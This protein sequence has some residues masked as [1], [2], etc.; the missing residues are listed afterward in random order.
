MAKIINED[1][2]IKYVTVR[3]SADLITI[4]FSRGE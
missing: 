4:R 2:T 1:G 3:G